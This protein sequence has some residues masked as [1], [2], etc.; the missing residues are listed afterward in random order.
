MFPILETPKNFV[1]RYV[2][3][4]RIKKMTG[5]IAFGLCRPY[6]NAVIDEFETMEFANLVAQY[7]DSHGGSY[8]AAE[9]KAAREYAKS[10]VSTE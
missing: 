10:C 8:A 5:T 7:I 1:G 2:W 4:R 9:R 3:V 6:S